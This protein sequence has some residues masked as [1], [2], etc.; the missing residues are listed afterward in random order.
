MPFE[1]KHIFRYEITDS[2]D[3]QFPN[4]SNTR[5]VEGDVTLAGIL[6][7]L[8]DYLEGC[9]FIINGSLGVIPDHP[10]YDYSTFS[11]SSE[12]SDIETP[13]KVIKYQIQTKLMHKSIKTFKT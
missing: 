12:S 7:A 4:Q 9:G 3:P 8:Q 5:E 10:V 13:P 1:H 11:E 2:D 6:E